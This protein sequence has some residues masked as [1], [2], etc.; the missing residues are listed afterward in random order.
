M[1]GLDIS[2]TKIIFIFRL[3]PCPPSLALTLLLDALH[4]VYTGTAS[5]AAVRN[6]RTSLL[7]LIRLNLFARPQVHCAGLCAGAVVHSRPFHRQRCRTTAPRYTGYDCAALFL[8][9]LLMFTSF[10]LAYPRPCYLPLPPSRLIQHS[11]DAGE[12]GYPACCLP[13]VESGA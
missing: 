9:V 4:P 10:S 5:G 3:C 12:R 6:F 7:Q 11:P 13:R 1:S 8:R 2:D